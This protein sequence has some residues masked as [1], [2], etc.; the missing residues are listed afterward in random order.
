VSRGW[1]DLS[2]ADSKP[3]CLAIGEVNVQALF[4]RVAAVVHRTLRPDLLARAQAVAAAVR[5][6]GAHVA[7]K[8]VMAAEEPS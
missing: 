1:A 5:N 6:D 8:Q 7:A 3:D 2:L 4:K